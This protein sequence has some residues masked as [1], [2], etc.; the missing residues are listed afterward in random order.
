V[1]GDEEGGGQVGEVVFLYL[2]V[3]GVVGVLYWRLEKAGCSVQ[4]APS[5]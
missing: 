3:G 4:E 2:I 1:G 5:E